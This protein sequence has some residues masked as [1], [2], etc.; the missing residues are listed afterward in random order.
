MSLD[1]GIQVP[2]APKHV[3]YVWV[4]AL[5]NYV[6]ATGLLNKGDNARKH[7]WPADLHVIGKDIVRFHAVYWPAFLMSAGLALPRRVFAHGFLY[8]KGEK[9]SKSVGNVVNPFDLVK[10][11]GVDQTRFFFLREA[12]FG[13]DGSYSHEAIVNRINADLANGLGNLAQRSLSMIAKGFAGVVPKPGALTAA[14]EALL[15]KADALY[16]TCR[17]AMDRQAIKAWLDAV[18]EVIGEADRY[19]ASE[20]PFDKTLSVER[21]GTILYVTAEVVRQLAVLAQPAMPTAAAKLLDLLGQGAGQRTFAA[22]GKAGRIAPGISL[23]APQG[24]FPRYVEP[25]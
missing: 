23:P 11:Y 21:K 12:A 7:L 13:Q 16:A 8:N 17:A 9:M 25:A 6:T 2:G 20:K 15:A 10:A 22:L 19:F 1:W 3:M 4:D 18:W 14:D 5:N 24:V